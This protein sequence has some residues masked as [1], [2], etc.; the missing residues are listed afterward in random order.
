MVLVVRAIPFSKSVNTQS[1]GSMEQGGR[2]EKMVLSNQGLRFSHPPIWRE[3]VWCLEQ[4]MQ[5]YIYNPKGETAAGELCQGRQGYTADSMPQRRA[6]IRFSLGL[7][8]APLLL[9]IFRRHF[10]KEMLGLPPAGEG[11]HS[12]V[13]VVRCLSPSKSAASFPQPQSSGTHY[14]TTH[15]TKLSITIPL[16]HLKFQI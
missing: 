16:Q 4:G 11:R 3:E 9:T 7:W 13:G 10:I 15:A 12:T 2:A 5:A 8:V 6:H 14:L 1:Q